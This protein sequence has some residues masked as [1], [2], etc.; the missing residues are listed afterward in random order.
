MQSSQNL[1]LSQP[2]TAALAWCLLGSVTI[3]GFACWWF[4]QRV[5][6]LLERAYTDNRSFE[7]RLPDAGW[8]PYSKGVDKRTGQSLLQA[9]ASRL[10][11]EQRIR[12]ELLSGRLDA[13]A[14]ADDDATPV[15]DPQMLRTAA[16]MTALRAERGDFPAGLG[17]T[18]EYT[19]RATQADPAD[20]ISLFNRALAFEKLEMI[21][22]ARED[23]TA[24]A[25][26]ETD[27]QWLAEARGHLG[28]LQE[29]ASKRAHASTSGELV[30]EGPALEWLEKNRRKAIEFGDPWLR[31]AAGEEVDSGMLRSLATASRALQSEKALR[32]AEAASAVYA[33]S[34]AH[35]ARLRL[36][37]IRA[38]ERIPRTRECLVQ[39]ESLSHEAGLRGYA[40]IEVQALRYWANCARLENRVGLG[41]VTQAR[42]T[43]IAAVHGYTLL[44]SLSQLDDTA[45]RMREG[46]PWVTW[47]RV[48]E[49]L[50]RMY[51][52]GAQVRSMHLA[53]SS[54]SHSAE[55]W[56]W[57]AAAFEF[58]RASAELIRTD[59]D[60]IATRAANHGRAAAM[61]LSAGFREAATSQRQMAQVLFGKLSSGWQRSSYEANTGLLWAEAQLSLGD[62]SGALETLEPLRLQLD[63]DRAKALTLAGQAHI[64]LGQK[65][66]ALP[67]LEQA[68]AMINQHIASIPMRAGRLAKRREFL[69][70]Y[71]A[72][73][74]LYVEHGQPEQALS[75]WLSA[76]DA[77]TS[78]S[79][80]VLTTE[81]GYALWTNGGKSF[82]VVKTDRAWIRREV[83]EIVR[84]ASRPDSDAAGLEDKVRAVQQ[85][86]FG[87]GWT[88]SS[89]L[90]DEEIAALPFGL[91]TPMTLAVSGDTLPPL[92]SSGGV[93]AVGATVTKETL[94]VLAQ[95]AP[96]AELVWRTEGGGVLLEG[97]K[98]AREAVLG[99]L[100]HARL[101]HFSGHGFAAGGL[102]GLHL[103]DGVMTSAHVRDLDL[104]RCELAVLSACLTGSGEALGR[105]N[106]ESFVQALLGAGAKRVLASRWNVDSAGGL[107]FMTHFYQRL[108]VS[109]DPADALR[110]AMNRMRREKPHPYYWA[111]FQ[112]FE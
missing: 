94:P 23:W 54:Y 45:D 62:P 38:L 108:S 61:A 26:L 104:S 106:L 69:D 41:H 53:L 1:P 31:Q 97:P 58:M 80:V 91:T 95:S 24:V 11:T 57:R 110:F 18:V 42:A 111:G 90:A 44:E 13:A 8:S 55:Q 86:V 30:F 64:R 16:V 74:R 19:T 32:I 66:E 9:R 43:R 78:P 89:L 82:R 2:R 93:L 85:T 84:I 75:A 98:V 92:H 39:A 71:R 29:A 50:G 59:E 76:H 21:D 77:R 15:R 103:A 83:T 22:R 67:A 33:S 63:V 51:R 56:G 37:K 102:T 27:P 49:V 87:A 70:T 34:P 88:A 109:R 79:T 40:W 73:A 10:S 12:L 107:V 65:A 28:K 35:L 3:I 60:L 48:P 4:T 99:E 96:E 6:K 20:R 105:A 36:E 52:S 5:D 17:A 47:R 81:D 25:V 112:L 101:F 68:L 14:V 46:E 100:S 7:W 72:L